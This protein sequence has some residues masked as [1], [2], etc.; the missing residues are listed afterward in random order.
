MALF[1]KIAFA[2]VFLLI[3]ANIASA[4]Y[5]VV[6]EPVNNKIDE[7]QTI[8]LGVVGPGQKLE[9]TT[10]RSS[11]VFDFRGVEEL[12]DRIKVEEKTLPAGWSKVDSLFYE[13]KPRAFAIVSSDAPDGDYILDFTGERD[14]G[15]LSNAPMH[16]KGKVKVSKNVFEF[17]VLNKNVESGIEQPAT[18]MLKLKNT[19]SASDVFEISVVSGLPKG[20]GFKK[21]VLVPYNSEKEVPYEI[22]PSEQAEFSIKLK[23][24]SLSSDKI[25]REQQVTL[26]AKSSLFQDAKAASKGVILF[27]TIEQV[28]YNL[29]GFISANLFN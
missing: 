26:V 18:F 19:G 7:G 21:T 15:E 24:V 5:I 12:W 27:P 3:I 9:I 25:S 11:G 14:Y 16:F 17:S 20:W 6:T 29:I 8:D 23:A 10:G 28:V 1:T 22:S 4:A 2:S 13:G